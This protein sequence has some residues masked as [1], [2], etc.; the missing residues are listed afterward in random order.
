MNM[1][2]LK[3]EKVDDF[4]STFLF[5]TLS[6]ASLPNYQLIHYINEK[7]DNLVINF[8]TA[9]YVYHPIFTEIGKMFFDTSIY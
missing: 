5:V 1:L 3:T 6:N 7:V 4:S 8:F 2:Y 9:R